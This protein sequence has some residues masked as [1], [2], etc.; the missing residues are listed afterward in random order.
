[1]GFVENVQGTLLGTVGFVFL[2]YTAIATV[3]KVEEALNFTWHVERPRSFARRAT[4]YLV[5]L[6]VVPALA[7]VA[8]ALLA[9]F[10]ASAVVAKLSGAGRG[11]RGRRD[12]APTSRPTRSSSGSSVS[13]T[14]T[15]RT[16]A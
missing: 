4:E 12:R 3:Q 15:C 5:V 16:R 10:E 9:S 1:M 8:M 14:S 13:C 7:V 2:L 11:A 6:L